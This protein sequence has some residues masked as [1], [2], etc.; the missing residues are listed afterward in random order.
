MGISIRKNPEPLKVEVHG[1][2]FLVRPMTYRLR[3]EIRA[4]IR[5]EGGGAVD[6]ERYARELHKA[7]L[8]G[9]EG[10]QF[11]DTG[12]AVPFGPC[13]ECASSTPVPALG[14]HPAGPAPVCAACGGSKDARD[15]ALATLPAEVW[16]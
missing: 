1:V 6:P 2:T 15:W 4:R 12:E 16:E 7:I 8:A 13:P 5:K 11:E 10:L 9:W 14:G 3:E